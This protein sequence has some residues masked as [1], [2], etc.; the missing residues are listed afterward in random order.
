MSRCV[1][2]VVTRLNEATSDDWPCAAW[3]ADVVGPL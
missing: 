2:G 3:R 1:E